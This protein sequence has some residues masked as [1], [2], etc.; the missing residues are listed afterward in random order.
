[1]SDCVSL[2]LEESGHVGN[3]FGSVFRTSRR[4]GDPAMAVRVDNDTMALEIGG[5]VVATARFREHAAR[6]AAVARGSSSLAAPIAVGMLQ[7]PGRSD[8]WSR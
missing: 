4:T 6:S 5:H 8:G 1:M 7:T 3:W 2:G